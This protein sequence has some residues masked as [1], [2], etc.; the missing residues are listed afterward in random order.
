VAEVAD[1]SLH[2]DR[3]EKGRIYARAGIPV[4]WIVNVVDKQIEVYTDP[5][6]T[7][8]PPAYRTRTDYKP[9]DQLPVTLHGKQA[10][11]IAV[12]EMLP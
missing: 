12:T 11:T 2:I 9:G 1:S 3:H 4:Y 5:D 8:N 6:P 7:A 10:A